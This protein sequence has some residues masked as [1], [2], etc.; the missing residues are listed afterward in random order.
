MGAA[1]S[2]APWLDPPPSRLDDDGVLPRR[3]GGRQSRA[4][5]TKA[6]VWCSTE[7]VERPLSVRWQPPAAPTSILTAVQQGCGRLWRRWQRRS[8]VWALVE[9]MAS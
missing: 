6:G 5:V 4:R 1:G 3:G 8:G 9:T 7:A 2:G